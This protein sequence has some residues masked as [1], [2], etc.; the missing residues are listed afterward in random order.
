VLLIPLGHAAVH[1]FS[2]KEFT[3]QISC[4][5]VYTTYGAGVLSGVGEEGAY[6]GGAECAGKYLVVVY[7]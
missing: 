3:L 6:R 5:P 1:S 4:Y 7:A 2:L